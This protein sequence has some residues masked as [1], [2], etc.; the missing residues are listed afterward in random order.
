MVQAN[1]FPRHGSYVDSGI[2]WLGE[3]PSDW[4]L[5]SIRAVTQLKSEKNRPALQVLSVYRDYGVITKDSRDDNHNATSLDTS[6]YKVVDEGDLVVNKMKAWQGSMGVSEH[7]G[8]VS[9][10]YITCRVDA[11]RVYP[12]FLH[13]LLRSQPYIGAYNALSYGVRVGQWDMHYEDFKRIPL[14]LP[15]RT[16]QQRIANFLDQKTVEIEAAI[17]KKQ[18]LTELLKEQKAI[19]I[20]QAVTKGLNHDVPMRDSGVEWMGK[21]PEHWKIKQLRHLTTKIGSGV[22]PSGGARV[23]LDEGALFIRSQNVHFDGL[24]LDDAKFIDFKTHKN[25]SNTQLKKNDVLLNITGASIGRSCV[26]NYSGEANVN[27]HVCIIRPKKEVIPQFLSSLFESRVGT[28]QVR[29]AQNGA[30]REGLTFA[31]LRAFLIPVPPMKEQMTIDKYISNIIENFS[32]TLST[33]EKE[34]LMLLDY[35]QVLISEAVTGKI[36]V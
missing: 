17:A 8:I 27:Q 35:K 18:R 12:K 20:N 28:E 19:L 24:R 22:T 36:K 26:F 25:M 31:D 11:E 29:L 30:S 3:I 9:P 21:I 15:D 7:N 5:E 16:L 33:I 23:Y 4:S 6:G 2:D 13:Y 1:T 14:P 32:L 10:A 34:I